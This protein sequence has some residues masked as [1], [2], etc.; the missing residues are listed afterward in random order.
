MF[1]PSFRWSVLISVIVFHLHK[2]LTC[3]TCWLWGVASKPIF[4]TVSVASACVVWDLSTHVFILVFQTKFG[5]VLCDIYSCRLQTQ[6]IDTD[7]HLKPASKEYGEMLLLSKVFS[8]P[9]VNVRFGHHFDRTRFR[10]C[11]SLKY[12]YQWFQPNNG[13]C[14]HKEFFWPV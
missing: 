9:Q 12:E 13:H 3:S 4:L 1:S 14:V 8:D 11:N 5:H 10:N 7:L 6:L 2:C